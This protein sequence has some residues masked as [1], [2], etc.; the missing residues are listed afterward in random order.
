M[1]I[2]REHLNHLRERNLRP[3]TIAQRRRALNRLRVHLGH[4]DLL[5]ATAD[6]LAGF[7]DRNI[8]PESR[9]TEISH[10]RGFYRWA[11]ME[12]RMDE[13][14]TMRLVRPKL[15]RRLPRPM[16]EGDLRRALDEAP[17][18]IRLMLWLA[19]HA[20]LRA[21]E[22]AQLR[23][24][25]VQLD[26]VPPV[27][28]VQESKGGGMSSVAMSP[29]LVEMAREL[30][31]RSGFLFPRMDGGAGPL[32]PHRVSQLVN[33]YLHRKHIVHTLH[34]A[35]HWYGTAF[36]KASGRDLRATQEAM[37]HLSPV[38]TSLYTWVDPGDLSTSAARLPTLA[39]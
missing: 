28:I 22:I 35:R 12:H 6:D 4:P 20:G 21:C 11:V 29:T 36:Y 24:E 5:A 16:P 3:G 17:D 25:H 31:P 33:Q 34:T 37:R 1:T 18:R 38:S 39:P 13:D 32:P 2:M 14:P 7:L 10:L 23:V 19:A 30:M 8:T 15:Y 27:I 26:A 9:A